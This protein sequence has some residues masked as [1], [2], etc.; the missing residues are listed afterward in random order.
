MS[1]VWKARRSTRARSVRH[2]LQ[3]LVGTVAIVASSSGNAAEAL[4][5]AG[6]PAARGSE[7]KFSAQAAAT[8]NGR[9]AAGG[10]DLRPLAERG[11]DTATATAAEA[12]LGS[13]LFDGTARFEHGAQRRTFCHSASG[14]HRIVGGSLGPDLATAEAFLCS[15]ALAAASAARTAAGGSGRRAPTF[16][17]RRGLVYRWRCSQPECCFA[18]RA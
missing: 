8:F 2:D 18:I 14:T 17:S 1:S 7:A 6:D 5:T 11:A 12:E 13:H 10:P 3:V 15:L 4:R 9:C 16:S